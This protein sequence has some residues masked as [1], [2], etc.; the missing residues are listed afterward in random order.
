MEA[1]ALLRQGE[2]RDRAALTQL[3]E[4]EAKRKLDTADRLYG[5]DR[6]G[7]D[8]NQ[9][10]VVPLYSD[11]LPQEPEHGFRFI[12]VFGKRHHLWCDGGW[13]EL[14]GELMRRI[15]SHGLRV[16]LASACAFQERRRWYGQT[17]RF[18][19]QEQTIMHRPAHHQDTSMVLAYNRHE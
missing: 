14:S 10:L 13:V 5:A 15:D 11:P 1:D 18:R 17:L 6:Y 2:G 12:A 9:P 16:D 19:D 7:R 8:V 4:E 3:R